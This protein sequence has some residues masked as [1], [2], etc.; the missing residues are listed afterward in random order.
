[1]QVLYDMPLNWW[2]NGIEQFLNGDRP[3]IGTISVFRIFRKMSLH[4]YALFRNKF[5][6]FILL[7]YFIEIWK[8]IHMNN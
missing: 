8:S 2:L 7:P 5:Y 6:F 3:L 1:M 4:A